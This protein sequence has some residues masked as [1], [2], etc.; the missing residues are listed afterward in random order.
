MKYAIRN[1]IIL[2]VILLLV[3]GGFHLTTIPTAKEVEKLKQAYQENV[4]LLEDLRAAHPNLEDQFKIEY[5]L[6]D[7]QEKKR[8][9]GKYILKKED[10][11]FSYQYFLDICQ[12]YSI[13]LDFDFNISQRTEADNISYNS[14]TITGISRLSDIYRF[15]YH[16]EKQ[17]LLYIIT[18]IDLSEESTADGTVRYTI[19]IQGYQADTGTVEAES[20]WRQLPSRTIS[21]DP[22]RSRIHGPIVRAQEEEFVDIQKVQVIG[23]SAE[24]VFLA[25]ENGSITI[26]KTG[27][28]VAYGYLDYINLE[29]QYA[30]FKL[31]QI[32]VTTTH[33]LYL[34][35]E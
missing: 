22:L 6:E 27:D 21:Y 7:L 9:T 32:G 28:K 11:I 14:Y 5:L 10:P 35:K 16:L 1:T 8:K 34:E 20:P 31:N 30:Q 26:L 12:R 33:K 19:T 23:L 29:E 15:L 18:N 17:Y 3:A 13:D 4:Q 24:K 25:E 2:S